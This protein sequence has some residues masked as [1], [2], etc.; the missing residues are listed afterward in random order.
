MK[1]IFKILL[2]ILFYCQGY[3]Q[4]SH[5][6]F[7]GPSIT[8]NT[9]LLDG[10]EPQEYLKFDGPSYKIFY[11]FG[12]RLKYRLNKRFAFNVEAQWKKIGSD[13]LKR[14]VVPL[15]TL[16]NSWQNYI[17][18]PLY[19][20]YM[21]TSKVAIETG[22]SSNY[23]LNEAASSIDKKS[24]QLDIR[25][26]F[27][28]CFDFLFAINFELS[29]DFDFRIRWE[30]GIDVIDKEFDLSVNHEYIKNRAFHF[31]FIYKF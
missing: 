19:L 10:I 3:S 17:C 24:P 29:K 6:F 15:D 25:P 18:I 20:S 28:S 21:A 27:K 4:F 26:Q 2:F 23:R 31:S 11:N 14:I 5:S 22:L 12:Y 8:Q 9:L 7:A 30:E 1:I 16:E 13:R